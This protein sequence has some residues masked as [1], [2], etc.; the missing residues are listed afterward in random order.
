[1]HFIVM[2][3]HVSDNTLKGINSNLFPTLETPITVNLI[4]VNAMNKE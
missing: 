3:E 2:L 4:G 1:M